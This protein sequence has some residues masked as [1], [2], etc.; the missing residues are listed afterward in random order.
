MTLSHIKE[1]LN[2]NV[3]ML[4]IWQLN[5]MIQEY[6]NDIVFVAVGELKQEYF[7]KYYQKD[8]TDDETTLVTIQ[9]EGLCKKK[10]AKAK[11]KI[12]ES[13]SFLQIDLLHLTLLK[14]GYKETCTCI[15]QINKENQELYA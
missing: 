9:K 1:E 2:D 6:G 15:Q 12:D 10:L 7:D 4:Q 13:L 8:E 14:R 11:M 5:D 3:S